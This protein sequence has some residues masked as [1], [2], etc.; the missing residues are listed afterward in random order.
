MA[1]QGLSANEISAR[2][3]SQKGH[4]PRVD[5]QAGYISATSEI[6][7][8]F[9]L[10]KRS[11]SIHWAL[12]GLCLRCGLFYIFKIDRCHASDTNFGIAKC[13]EQTNDFEFC[14]TFAAKIILT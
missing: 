3:Y 2:A 10:A 1:V 7:S 4:D 8:E 6:H 13:Q 5:K 14:Y 12:S 11:R 9:S